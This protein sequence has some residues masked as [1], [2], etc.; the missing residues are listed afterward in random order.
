[1]QRILQ[2]LR[3]LKQLGRPLLVGTSRKTMIRSLV[4]QTD[5][6]PEVIMGTAAAVAI[7]VLNGAD[8]I[9][10]HDVAE[11]VPVVRVA[12]GVARGWRPAA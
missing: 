11:M 6:A 10:V 2:R 3:E 8:M 1:M 12:D 4:S 5:T 9:R 7:S